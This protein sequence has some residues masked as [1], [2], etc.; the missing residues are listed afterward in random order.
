MSANLTSSNFQGIELTTYNFNSSSNE[1]ASDGDS[2]IL[3]KSGNLSN[4]LALNTGIPLW[5]E[6]ID[7]IGRCKIKSERSQYG[8]T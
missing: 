3:A 7:V 2:L 8:L 1:I 6:D 5:F 4:G